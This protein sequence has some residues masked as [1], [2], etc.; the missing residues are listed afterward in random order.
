MGGTPGN[1]T[2]YAAGLVQ[3]LQAAVVKE[4]RRKKLRGL[5]SKLSLPTLHQVGPRLGGCSSVSI[6]AFLTA[7]LVAVASV[8]AQNATTNGTMGGTPG[9]LNSKLSLPTLHQVGPRLGGCSSADRHG[10]HFLSWG[11]YSGELLLRHTCSE[12]LC[13][14]RVG[15]MV[16]GLL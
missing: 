14:I 16:L 15:E 4:K 1:Q 6:K 7:A 11:S 2:E 13:L 12:R 9:N 3:A 10:S 8:S 5:N